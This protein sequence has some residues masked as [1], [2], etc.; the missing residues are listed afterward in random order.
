MA[1]NATNP[2]A[3]NEITKNDGNRNRFV[4]VRWIEQG[5]SFIDHI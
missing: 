1:G 4:D 3:A 5:S 2:I